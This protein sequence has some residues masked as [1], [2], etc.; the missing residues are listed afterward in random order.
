MVQNI[1]LKGYTELENIHNSINC[2]NKK[3]TCYNIRAY[4]HKKESPKFRNTHTHTHTHT[5]TCPVEQ[6]DRLTLPPPHTPTHTHSIYD[7]QHIL[8]KRYNGFHSGCLGTHSDW[9]LINPI[10]SLKSKYNGLEQSMSW[11]K[12]L[13]LQLADHCILSKLEIKHNIKHCKSRSFYWK[14]KPTL[15]LF[16]YFFCFVSRYTVVLDV[17][18]VSTYQMMSLG[19]GA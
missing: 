8:C 10:S 19:P 7:S 6:K 9:D 18:I 17:A 16:L 15:W 4:I 13:W 5:H 2:F 1:E 11:K 3:Q 12:N 14:K